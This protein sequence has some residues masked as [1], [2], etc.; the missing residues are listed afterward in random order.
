M[1]LP[2]RHG[3]PVELKIPGEP[4]NKS[5]SMGQSVVKVCIIDP[6]NVGHSNDRRILSDSIQKRFQPSCNHHSLLLYRF[7]LLFRNP[8]RAGIF[9]IIFI[10]EH[11]IPS[12]ISSRSYSWIHEIPQKNLQNIKHRMSRSIVLTRNKHSQNVLCPQI[13]YFHRFNMTTLNYVVTFQSNYYGAH[14]HSTPNHSS[15]RAY[16]S[17]NPRNTEI[18][19]EI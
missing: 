1:L 13:I 11:D 9:L 17:S 19:Y 7:P 15:S 14:L 4:S 16:F 5:R 10:G 3:Y 18:T 6:V 8:V 2:R 12:T